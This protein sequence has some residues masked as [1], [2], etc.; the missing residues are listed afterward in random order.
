MTRGARVARGVG[1][2]F[3][4]CQWYPSLHPP[5]RR[6]PPGR[7][8]RA[9]ARERA[10]GRAPR[11]RALA[12]PPAGTARTTRAAHDAHRPRL[13]RAVQGTRATCGTCENTARGALTTPADAS[14][15]IRCLATQSLDP[16]SPVSSPPATATFGDGTLRNR[17]TPGSHRQVHPRRLL[18]AR[19]TRHRRCCHR[20]PVGLRGLGNRRGHGAKSRGGGSPSLV[21]GRKRLRGVS[22]KLLRR[23]LRVSSIRGVD[24]RR[25]KRL[26][27][28][29]AMESR[30]RAAHAPALAGAA[31]A[32]RSRAARTPPERNTRGVRLRGAQTPRHSPEALC[33]A[34]PDGAHTPS[35]SDRSRTPS[36]VC[37]RDRSRTASAVCHKSWTLPLDR[38]TWRPHA[39]LDA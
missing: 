5:A 34:A 4:H 24:L 8:A 27:E 36:A 22:G 13:G 2:A 18:G 6:V 1:G 33:S 35:Q 25:T 31:L 17:P 32:L 3:S 10:D 21:L 38:N 20:G 39:R 14:K 37:Q 9:H 7:H 16:P 19:A 29:A 23:M 12:N 28:I 26:Q 30:P 11:A 15:A